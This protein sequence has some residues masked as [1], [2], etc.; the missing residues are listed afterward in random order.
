M[1]CDLGLFVRW[2]KSKQ[3]LCNVHE[4]LDK[5]K[6]IHEFFDVYKCI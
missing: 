4:T 6:T 3:K 5:T 1:F 2:I